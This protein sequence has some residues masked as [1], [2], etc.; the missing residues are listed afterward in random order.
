MLLKIILGSG[1]FL[2]V[3]LCF[4]LEEYDVVHIMCKF[5]AKYDLPSIRHCRCYNFRW[6]RES[7]S[8]HC[9]SMCAH[10]TKVF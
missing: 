2:F 4:D 7:N 9:Y 5:K 6:D 8:Y 3:C 1:G 10:N